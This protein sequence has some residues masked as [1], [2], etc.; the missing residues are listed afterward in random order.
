MDNI[1]RESMKRAGECLS[2]KE[3]ERDRK[4]NKILNWGLATGFG[5]WAIQYFI[6]PF[7]DDENPRL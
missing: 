1:Q 4:R 6:V 3:N 7:G 2:K 5:A